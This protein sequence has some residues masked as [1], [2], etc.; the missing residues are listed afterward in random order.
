MDL[1]SIKNRRGNGFSKMS[2]FWAG[3][4]VFMGVGIILWAGIFALVAWVLL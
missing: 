1:Q 4:L 2:D 3:L